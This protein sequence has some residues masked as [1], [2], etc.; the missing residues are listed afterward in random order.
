VWGYSA[1]ITADPEA[2]PLDHCREMHISEMKVP[3][4]FTR[5]ARK[6]FAN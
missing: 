5:P 2:L 4:Y 6:I 1:P 3:I